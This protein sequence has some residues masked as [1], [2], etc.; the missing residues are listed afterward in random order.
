MKR[1]LARHA[2]TLTVATALVA[3]GFTLALAASNCGCTED[4]AGSFTVSTPAPIECAVT[5]VTNM[6]PEPPFDSAPITLGQ[7][8]GASRTK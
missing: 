2:T 1:T 6:A 4:A 5:S 3:F 7:S 8:V